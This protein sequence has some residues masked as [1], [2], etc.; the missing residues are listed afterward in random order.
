MGYQEELQSKLDA[1][2]SKD[3]SEDRQVVDTSSLE[4][5]LMDEITEEFEFS[6]YDLDESDLLRAIKIQSIL[7]QY[8]DVFEQKNALRVFYALAKFDV[9]KA[10]NL[11]KL[12][13]LPGEAFKRLV[14]AMIQNN[15]A[16]LNSSHELEMTMEG[17]SL[18]ERIGVQVFI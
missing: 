16:R 18:A 12:S 15:L 3:T 10:G 7:T 1:V 5:K 2:R 13:L 9:I 14:N 4:Q 11:H 17:Q 8:P 6:Q